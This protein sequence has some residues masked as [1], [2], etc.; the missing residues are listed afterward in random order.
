MEENEALPD[1]LRCNRTD[2]RQWRCKRRVEEGK[3]LCEIHYVQGRH[4]QMKQ[5]VPESLKIVRNT[6]NKNQS[7]IK[8]PKGSLEIG[9]SKSERALRILKKRKPLKHKPCVSEALDEALRRM[10]LKR[11]DLPLELI[12]VF[13]KRQLEKKNEK[14]S[15]NASAEVMREFPNAL[16]AIPII[17]AK[18]FNNAGSV[19]DVKLGLD[20]SSNPFSLR[21]FRS[22][23]I[24][25]LPISTMQALPFAR[26]VK[27]LSKVKRRRLCH[28][29]RRSSY[30]VLIKCSSC[31]KQ[32]FCLD[33]IKE[34]NLEQQE[35][36]VKC[37]ICRRDCSCRICKRSELKPNSHKE[38]SRHKRKVPKVQLL[39][40]L[41]HLLLPILEKINEEQRIE[42]EIEANISGK[43]E[44]DIQ[45]QQASAGDGK[46]YHCS[47]CNTSI[48]DY[49][50][51]CS[52]CS[53]SLC[54]YC[55]RDSRHGSLTEDCKSEGSN[56][57]QACSSNFER[58]SRM[59]YTSTSRQS[60]SG[61]HYPS[62]RSCSN[63]QACADGSISCPPA[64]YGGCSDSFL[65]LRCVFP[66]PWIK[67]LEISAEAILCSY[68]IQDT[69]H[70]FSSCSL[71]RGSDHKDAVANSFIKVAERQNSRDKFLYCPS[72]KNLRE[73]NLEHFQKH[74]GEGHPIIVRNVLRNSSDLSWDPVVMFSTYLEKRS[75]C[76][77]D[78]E[79]AKAQN[80]S[81]WCEVEIARK[82]IF[83]GSLEWQTH[84]T[85]QREIV[86]FRAWLSSHLFQ[87]Q[88]PVH[89]AEILRA[90]PL[91]EYMNP[92]SGLLNL[93]VK[94]PPEMPQTDLGPSI[95]ISYGGPEELLQAEFITNLCCESYDMVNI[96]ASAT[97]VLASKE[98]VR[99]IKCLMKNKKPQ[100]HK[101][102]TSH[103]SD[104]KGKSSLHSGDTEESDLQD[105]T[106]EQLPDGIA[107]IPFYSSD[108]Q[109]GQRYE[110]RDS[111][112][113][114]DN[115]NDSESE[116][117]VSLFC[118]G[119]VERSEDS[120]SDYFFEDV[121]GAKKEAKPSG[122]QWDV[123][124]RQDV[125]KLLE[126]LKR[127][128]SEFTSMRGYSKQ[129][130][131]PILDQSFFFDA[132][133]KLR[134]KEEFD[135]QPWTFEQHLGEAIIIPAG[136]PY[137]VKQLKS[138]INV[139][140]HFISPENVAECINV[141]D[142]IRL[143]PEH[144]KARGKM[145]EVKKMVI[146]GM[147]NAIAEIRDLT[148]TKQSS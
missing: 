58:Q 42:V 18:N 148:R 17:P 93:A 113:S 69:E 9:F 118:S 121:D 146:C 145:L 80:H 16:M 83:M 79:T 47:N 28:W 143:L 109:K 71:C 32:Y 89:H 78:K 115:E 48:L 1:D 4:R 33:C 2:G 25:P 94:L 127:H 57:E 10:E 23:N 41:V 110:D 39:Y 37:P 85:M 72:I 55:C 107:D 140:L 88:F 60:F 36:R 129:V 132:F 86:K 3:K 139:V 6:K 122:A 46:L 134:L 137:Q 114:S 105:A 120:D 53:Y 130:V 61:I 44:S 87:E 104:Q 29:C 63:N 91:Q 66:Y 138:C 62:S 97:D 65:D 108:S 141:T 30:R 116:S 82:Q 106:G 96:L 51:I 27:N 90:L 26:N 102:I 52:K 59:N 8:N 54:L 84:A 24:E 56:E 126:Y 73:E 22:K 70:D 67:E 95:Y 103:F 136:C 77:S 20:S 19:L 92:K 68:N 112:I 119:S 21:R 38:S 75:K 99:K 117:D 50:R 128:S 35:I 131:H 81:D 124:S 43:G 125:P 45:I 11:G 133:H 101:E 7:K 123:F 31:K 100:D 5:K 142:E 15:K 144:H 74:W 49:H 76:S 64:E 98:Q 12:R 111:N 147:N 13:L 40:Y 135:V 14:E 34:R